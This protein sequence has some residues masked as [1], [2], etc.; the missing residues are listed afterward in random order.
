M[1]KDELIALFIGFVFAPSCFAQASSGVGTRVP[2]KIAVEWLGSPQSRVVLDTAL[3]Y[4]A[5]QGFEHVPFKDYW[6]FCVYASSDVAKDPQS[7]VN[8]YAVKIQVFNRLKF[9][10]AYHG[11]PFDDHEA[12]VHQFQIINEPEFIAVMS[13]NQLRDEL[14]RTLDRFNRDVFSTVQSFQ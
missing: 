1:K 10:S 14:L 9:F 4:L 8:W 13:Q 3:G 11:I 5:K 12:F 7:G 6:N 2:V